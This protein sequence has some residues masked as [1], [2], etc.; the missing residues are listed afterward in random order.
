MANIRQLPD[1]HQLLEAAS[2]WLARLKADDVNEDDRRQFAAWR[3]AH[4][5][6]ARAFAELSATWE[7]FSAAA[8]LVRAVSFAQSVN[9]AATAETKRVSTERLRRRM[10]ASTLAAGLVV[11]A[12]GLMAWYFSTD[13]PTTYSTAIGEH[14]A[15]SLADGS[16]LELNSDSRARV[17]YAEKSRIVHLDRG[18]AFFTVAHD[19]S[20][21]FW[22]V[23]NGSWVRAVGT[24]FNV[25]VRS[26]GVYVTVSEGRVK[27]GPVNSPLTPIPADDA[28]SVTSIIEAGQ[29]VDVQ[30]SALQTRQ[31]TQVQLARSVGWREGVLNFENQPLSEV[32]EE[33]QR[34]TPIQLVIQEPRLRQLPVG[35]TFQA[36]PQGAEAF[37]MMLDRGFGLSVRRE[38]GRVLIEDHRS[39]D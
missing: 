6:H 17:S 2:Q 37:L 20:R 10:A 28:A 38:A 1:P 9:E 18:E 27:V 7:R 24:A 16:I 22:V 15:I 29:E 26:S 23:G 19:A 31:L 21:P 32:V 5:A 3:D 39:R 14:A 8:P 12:L 36:G 25:D 30:G 33:L 35:G 4:P 34:Y 13:R 11:A